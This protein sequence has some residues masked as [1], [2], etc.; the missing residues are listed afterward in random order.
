MQTMKSYFVIFS[1]LSI[2]SLCRAQTTIWTENFN[3]GCATGCLANTYNGPNGAWSIASVGTNGNFAN[4]WFV[5]GAECGMQPNQCGTD[6]GSTNSSL[7]IG[8]NATLFGVP[9]IDQGASYLAGASPLGD[10]TT[11][12]R[13]ESPVINTTGFENLTISFNYIEN[14]QGNID[15]A[16]LWLFNGTAWSMLTDMPKT[17]CCG[18]VPCTG[19]EQGLWQSFTFNLPA[20]TFNNP[21]IRIGFFW[22]NNNDNVGTDP[23]VAIDDIVIQG[24]PIGTSNP[25]VA[26]FVFSPNSACIGQNVVFTD[27]STNIAGATYSWNFGPN[28]TPQTANTPGP[29]TVTFNAVGAQTVTLTVTTPNGSSTST[30]TFTVTPGPNVTTSPDVQICQG[31]STIISAF[32]A[33]AYTWDNGLGIGAQHLVSPSVTTTYT[34]IGVDAQGCTGTASVTVVVDGVG[35]QLTMSSVD[36]VCFGTSTGQASVV[37]V[38]NGPF[39]YQWSPFGGTLPVASNLFPGNYTVTVTDAN[40]CVSTGSTTVGSPAQIQANASITNTDCNIN[41]GSIL[42]NP[43]GGNGNYTY[44]WLPGGSTSQLIANLPAG[45]YQVTIT[46]GNNCSQQFNFAIDLNDDFIVS[47]TPAVSSIP[48]LGNV[49][50]NTTVTPSLPGAIYSWSP[51][52]NLSCINCPNP[53]ASPTTTTSYTVTVTAPNGCSQSAQVLIN[54]DLPCGSVF[55]PTIFSP[56]GDFLNDRLCVLGTCIEFSTYTIYNRWGEEVFTSRNQSECWNG[57]FRGKPAPNGVYAYK[58]QVTLTDGTVLEDSGTLTLVR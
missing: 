27:A 32:G 41:N 51:A 7:H 33:G 48:Y 49:Q 45:N 36:A 53:I 28:A 12:K 6:C 16:Q 42:L 54:V 17:I 4:E 25:P 29:H 10:A 35:P 2:W 19:S 34:V 23:S 30:Q 20:A 47:A 8:S 1:L 39:T 46:D 40:G 43:S 9:L 56:N 24:F 5:S 31:G 38:G 50:L 21:N 58:L 57:T 18:N 22:T 52:T 44:S 15:N 13:V 11:N 26:N 3:N 14:G 55:M 37:A